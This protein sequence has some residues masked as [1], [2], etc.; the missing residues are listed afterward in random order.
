M[1]FSLSEFH[2][3]H[4]FVKKTRMVFKII[5]TVPYPIIY[6][7]DQRRRNLFMSLDL[8]TLKAMSEDF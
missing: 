5:S 7:P 6:N 2:A 1:V 4:I 3:P 8:V